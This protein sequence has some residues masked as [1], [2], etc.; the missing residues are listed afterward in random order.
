MLPIIDNYTVPEMGHLVSV[1][2]IKE[3]FF[4]FT[5]KPR[6]ALWEFSVVNENY[7]QQVATSLLHKTL[8][9]VS[10]VR[11]SLCW[12]YTLSDA[13]ACGIY[14]WADCVV[15]CISPDMGDIMCE[16][17]VND[18]QENDPDPATEENVS[19]YSFHLSICLS[20]YLMCV[21]VYVCIFYWGCWRDVQETRL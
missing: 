1:F 21:C 14:W 3:W 12:L 19:Q 13:T 20:N 18:T 2:I 5:L 9:A 10:S 4:L 8:K 11:K 17:A 16:D 7:R 15:M 6:L